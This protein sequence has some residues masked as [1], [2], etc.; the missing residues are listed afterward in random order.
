MLNSD[1]NPINPETNPLL[2]WSSTMRNKISMSNALIQAQHN[3]DLFS[4]RLFFIVLSTVNPHFSS[5]DR[6]YD[7]EFKDAFISS[8]MLAQ[9]LGGSKYLGMIPKACA[10]LEKTVHSTN[11][12]FTFRT[13]DRD[14]NVYS[15]FHHLE[16]KPREGLYARFSNK[17]YPYIADLLHTKG[18]TEIKLEYLLN[19]RSTYAIRLLQLLLQFQNIRRFQDMMEIQRTL[20]IEQLRFMLNVP[21]TAYKGRPDNFKRHVVRIPVKEINAHTPYILHFRP[22]RRGNRTVAFQFMLST[23]QIHEKVEEGPKFSNH[24]IDKLIDLGFSEKAARAILFR[25]NNGPD[26][27][28]RIHNA[29][30]LFSHQQKNIKN[31]LGFLR[32]A[33]ENNWDDY[34]L[35]KNKIREKY[36]FD[37]RKNEEFIIR[38]D[39]NELRPLELKPKP[40]SK[41]KKRKTKENVAAP[42]SRTKDIG[43]RPTL[44]ND[45]P[46]R[47]ENNTSNTSDKNTDVYESRSENYYG[48]RPLQGNYTSDSTPQSTSS[49]QPSQNNFA[50][51]STQEKSTFSRIGDVMNSILPQ[52]D[53]DDPILKLFPPNDYSGDDWEELYKKRSLEIQKLDNFSFKERNLAR[54]AELSK[55]REQHKKAQEARA[56]ANNLK[57]AL[58][59][60]SEL[61]P[62]LQN[63]DLSDR[64]QRRTIIDIATDIKNQILQLDLRKTKF[65]DEFE[66]Q[67]ARDK[68]I[69]NELARRAPVEDIS[70]LR[71]G[72][73]KTDDKKKTIW[74]E[75]L[76]RITE[77][78]NSDLTADEKKDVYYKTVIDAFIQTSEDGTAP[79]I[80]KKITP[81]HNPNVNYPLF[82]NVNGYKISDQIL[83]YYIKRSYMTERMDLVRSELKDMF[84]LTFEEV[85]VLYV[86]Y[87]GELPEPSKVTV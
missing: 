86:K 76:K 56:K 45:Q 4:M 21:E 7:K 53:V 62:S 67:D 80:L 87:F 81:N 50:N 39:G 24:A 18:Y 25:C 82:I 58:H 23:Y 65:E 27:F 52:N 11:G 41:R 6:Y 43:S 30:A 37:F 22:V 31:K 2:I 34:Y 15:L 84:K 66:E 85:I 13:K 72:K 44:P 28:V 74:Q 78:Y 10:K 26:C 9:L 64:E 42:Y 33:I 36:S 35:T 69:V 57:S 47:N 55:A 71:V 59:R 20:T 5:K 68:M 16:Y 60:A 73:R 46:W 8:S 70:Y 14:I 17:V 75:T 61:I 49:N 1:G 32:K 48:N 51:S 77:I 29:L 12:F 79:P 54:F 38:S 40:K 83:E 19:L 63:I 3:L